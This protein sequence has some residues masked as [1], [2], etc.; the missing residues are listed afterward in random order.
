MAAEQNSPENA[1]DKWAQGQQPNSRCVIQES[2]MVIL[3]VPKLICY[4]YGC[5]KVPPM[6]G[7]NTGI[8]AEN[9]QL[10]SEL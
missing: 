9:I 3:K 10:L 1:W 4:V 6:L 8:C 7:E 5:Y 2:L